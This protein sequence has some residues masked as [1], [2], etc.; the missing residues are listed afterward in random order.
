MQEVSDSLKES[1]KLLGHF[2]ALC[3]VLWGICQM[4]QV[5]PLMELIGKQKGWAVKKLTIEYSKYQE[6]GSTTKCEIIEPVQFSLRSEG[7]PFS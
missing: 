2:D 6:R 1:D 7:F 4:Q 5:Q 3:W